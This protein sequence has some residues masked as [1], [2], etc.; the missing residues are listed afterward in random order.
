M[1]LLPSAKD[2]KV[3]VLHISTG[4]SPLMQFS[5]KPIVLIFGNLNN[6]TGND[7]EKE[8]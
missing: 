3:L 2:V 8:F 7:P 1:D 5:T 6:S 4:M